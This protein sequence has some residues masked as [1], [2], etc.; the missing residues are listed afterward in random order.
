MF[1]HKSNLQPHPS[2]KQFFEKRGYKAI[3]PRVAV[4][5]GMQL[6]NYEMVLLR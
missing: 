5:S 6:K 2:A 1:F 4:R 3:A